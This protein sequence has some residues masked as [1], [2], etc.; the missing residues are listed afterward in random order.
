MGDTGEGTRA[1]IAANLAGKSQV[2]AAASPT[3][4]FR[5]TAC[6]AQGDAVL[7][8]GELAS[9]GV[10]QPVSALMTITVGFGMRHVCGFSPYTAIFGALRRDEALRFDVEVVGAP[11]VSGANANQQPL[12]Q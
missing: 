2:D 10:A 8:R 3:F 1:K 5:S 9:H 7:V 4:A 6:V 11:S 12:P